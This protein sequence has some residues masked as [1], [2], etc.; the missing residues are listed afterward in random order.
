MKSA[1]SK[2][3]IFMFLCLGDAVQTSEKQILVK[4]WIPKKPWA[5]MRKKNRTPE[6][7]CR[8]E[9]GSC[10]QLTV[11]RKL[12]FLSTPQTTAWTPTRWGTVSSKR[13]ATKNCDLM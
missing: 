7:E 4:S 5:P 11:T 10:Q 6:R 12:Y 2:L 13:W 3:D 1:A 9:R 8:H